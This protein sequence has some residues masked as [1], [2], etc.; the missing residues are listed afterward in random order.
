MPRYFPVNFCDRTTGIYAVGAI[1]A[2]LFH[3]ECTGEGQAIDIPMFETMAQ[4]LL[5]DNLYGVSTFHPPYG[6]Q[7]DTAASSRPSEDLTLQKDGYVCAVIYNDKHWETFFA[8]AGKADDV[9]STPQYQTMGESHPVHQRI[10]M[11][12]GGRNL[13]DPNHSRLDTESSRPA[14]IPVPP[15]HSLDSLL[16]DPTSSRHSFLPGRGRPQRGKI[17]FIALARRVVRHARPDPAPSAP[18]RRAQPGDPRR[19][20]L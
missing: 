17:P 2:A 11:A 4:F 5:G 15:M 18:P 1:T 20:G 12:Y 9:S 13:R 10:T 3:R 14:D 6:F 19:E 7:Q 8:L 16:Q